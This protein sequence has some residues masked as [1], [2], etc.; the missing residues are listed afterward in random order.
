MVEVITQ[1]GAAQVDE[2]H[3][4]TL[5]VSRAA[6]VEAPLTPSAPGG[7]VAGDD[8]EGGRRRS[9]RLASRHTHRR[10]TGLKKS[11]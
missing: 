8:A 11:R 6:D 4:S 3:V 5:T 10:L 1:S 2:T 7:G 9:G